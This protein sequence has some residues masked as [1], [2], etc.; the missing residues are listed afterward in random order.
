MALPL[1]I[2]LVFAA[3]GVGC[4]YGAWRRTLSGGWIP[5]AAG[6]LLL[7]GSGYFWVRASGAEFGVS[8]VLMASPLMAWL[9]VGVNVQRRQRRSG[10]TPVA[11]RSRGGESVWRHVLRFL[12]VVPAAATASALTAVA[13]SMALPWETVN[14]VMLVM[15][16]LPVLWGFA[17][18]WACADAR[19]L[20][21]AA[22]MA[23][24]A[25]L[26]V[27]VIYT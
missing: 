24:S 12:L 23:A 2:A 19:L 15:I 5:V 17:A 1:S 4:L 16:V 11:P 9:F 13:L 14:A 25:L 10:A 3:T 7:A 8:L 27:A 26:S 21:P 6:W 22:A 18:Y 20:R